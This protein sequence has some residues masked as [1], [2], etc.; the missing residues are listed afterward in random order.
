[1]RI[2]AVITALYRQ[3]DRQ[4]DRKRR[5]ERGE[6]REERGER[7]YG[8]HLLVARIAY[9]SFGSLTHTKALKKDSYEKIREACLK[10]KKRALYSKIGDILHGTPN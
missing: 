2:L 5:E 4:T 6:R 1:M 3:V 9:H 8:F 7:R 10:K